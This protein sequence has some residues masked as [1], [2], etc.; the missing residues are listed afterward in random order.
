MTPAGSAANEAPTFVLPRMPPSVPRLGV[1]DT[2]RLALRQLLGDVDRQLAEAFDA[3][4]P[5]GELLGLRARTVESVIAHVWSACVGQG[6]GLALFAVGGFGRG[7][8]FPHSDVDLLALSRQLPM[9]VQLRG[10]EHFF[11]C[12]W[13]IGLKPGQAVRDLA[14]CR[15]LASEDVTV[16]TSLLD[17]RCL[18]GDPAM[19]Q[20]L[21]RIIDDPALWPPLQYL[22]AK[23]A[24]QAMRH[25]RFDDTALNLEP[26]LKDGPGGLRTLDQLRWLGRRVVAA[27]DFEALIAA[28]LLDPAEVA[29]LADAQVV[30]Q[31]YRYALHLEAGRA[32]E[33]LLFDY[34]RALANRLGFRDDDRQQQATP[35]P[36]TGG[37]P[38]LGVEQFMQGYYRAANVVERLGVQLTE[39]FEELLEPDPQPLALDAEF[40]AVGK[41]LESRDADLF[42]RRPAALIDAFAMRI[43]HPELI[44]F[45]AQTMRRIQQAQAMLRVELASDAAVLAAFLELLRRG[46]PAVEAMWQ[47]N[48]HGVLAAILPVFARVV[49]RMQYDLF[50]VYTV[51]E[52]TLRVLRYIAYF[53]QPEARA[54]FPVACDIFAG[55]DKPELLLLAALFHDIAKGRG[56]DHSTLGEI[57]AREFCTRLGLPD[58]DTEL[59]AWLVR[60]HLLMSTTAQRQDITDPAVVLRFAGAVGDWERLEHLYLLTIADIR[61]TSPRLWNSWK[62]RL[63]VDLYV[64]TRYALRSDLA[65]PLR[66]DLRVRE[67]RE[68]ATKILLEQGLDA[69]R[70]AKVWA[71]FPA[72]SFLRHRPEQIAWQTQAIVAGG[73]LPLVAVHPLSIRGTTELFVC[74]PDRDGLFAAISTVLD[75]LRFTV[76][77]ARVLGSP[78]GLA[79]DTFL[80]LDSDTQAPAAST[81]TTQLESTL[82]AALAHTPYRSRPVQR[83]LSRRLRHFQMAPQIEF[84]DD[85]AAL[86]TQLALVCT[87]RPGLL[88]AVAQAFLDAGVHVHDARVATF[89]ERV[90]DFFQIT[91]AAGQLLSDDSRARLRDALRKRIGSQEG[92]THANA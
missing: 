39:R 12:L 19:A 35:V 40:L 54:A 25:A 65:L 51:D 43:E 32:E 27:P 49:G 78:T 64:A 88:A 23:R 66:A 83:N 16:F 81:R 47:M 9:A 37:E 53:A 91:D 17:A 72:V 46:A 57:E 44:G 63:L 41:R 8:L 52:H 45:T 56:G 86:R 3:G 33:R 30:L 77:E 5:V 62:S 42:L 60:W 28:D 7:V 2:A 38:L 14:Q 31:R 26:N 58:E 4:V 92:T 11:R 82:R 15:Q 71:D 75:R 61:G 85:K 59:V 10:L 87:D 74:A 50:H 73:A 48:R 80:L 1:P 34:Q 6:E 36:V 21:N 13:D 22:A 24:E 90:E 18:C 89:G 79:F 84:V 55:L 68:R 29:A 69:E 20:M 70:I 76:M 67:C